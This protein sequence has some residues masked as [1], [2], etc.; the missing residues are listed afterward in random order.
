VP[1]RCVI[2]DDNASFLRAA[3][4]LLERQGLIVAGLAS[5]G[6]DALARARE[7][8]PDVVLLDIALGDES[9]F[10]VARR[11]VA[12]DPGGAKVILIST[13]AEADF[14]DLIDAT[15]AAGFVPKAEL[16][17]DAIQRLAVRPNAPR[18]T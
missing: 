10:D 1:L 16:S 6:A 4:A 13:H 12:A 3:A 7:L 2:V 8:R 9:G 14:A 15:P 11:M 5:N 18:G 17:A